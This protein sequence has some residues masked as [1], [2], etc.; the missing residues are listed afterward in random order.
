LCIFFI[1]FIR[2]ASSDI[3][4]SDFRTSDTVKVLSGLYKN[5]TGKIVGQIDKDL[6]VIEI[7]NKSK[8]C[9]MFLNVNPNNIKKE[10]KNA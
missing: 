1:G 2:C 7:I 5:C 6:Y 10:I 8:Y 9:P 4:Y 3:S